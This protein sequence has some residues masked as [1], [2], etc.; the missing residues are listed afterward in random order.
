MRR[1]SVAAVILLCLFLSTQ[2]FGQTDASVSG[3]VTDASGGVIPGVTVTATNDNTGIVTT[4]VTNAAGVYNF[5][6]LLPGVYTVKAEQADF[7][8]KTITKLSL[9][10]SQQAR[11][12]FQLEVKG[13]ETKVEI[14]TSAEQLLLESGSSVGDVLD[15]EKVA[16][17]PL[18]NRNAL[19]LVKV[20]SGVVMADD[21][22]FNANSSSFAGVSA[23]G[24]NIQRDGVTVNDVR[25]PA[26]INAAT[27]VNPDLVGEFRMVLAP[28]DA[29]IG[30]GN[31][32]IQISTRSGTNE[33]HGSLVWNVQNTA[34]DPNTWE[35]NRNGTDPPWRNLHQYTASVGGPII[36][37]K[38]FFFALFDGQVNKIRTPYNTRV[39]TPCANQGIFRFYDYWNNGNARTTPNW[40][41][42]TPVYPLVNPDGSPRALPALKP[43]MLNPDGTQKPEW[44]PHNGVIRFASVFGALREGFVPDATCSN[45]NPAT[46]LVGSAWDANRSQE[47]PSGFVAE[48]KNRMPEVNNWDIGDGLNTAGHRWSRTLLGA[49]NLFGVGEDT[50][51]RQI[52]VRIDHNFSD[53][54]RIH[55]SWS[56]EKSWADDNFKNWPDGYGGKS[57]RRPQIL[58]VNLISSIRPTLLNEARFGMSRTGSNIYSPYTNPDTGAEVQAILPNVNGTPLIVG[59]GQGVFN[60]TPDD[61]SGNASGYFGGR[62]I[63]SYSGYDTSPRWTIGDTMSWTKGSHSFRFGGEYRR[64]S[65][66]A[67]NQWTGPFTA[68]YNSF[69]YAGGGESGGPVQGINSGNLGFGTGADAR[70]TGGSTTGNVSAM[71]DQLTYLSGALTQIRQWRYINNSSD[72]SWNDP[73]ADP[74]LVRDTVQKEFSMFF[75]DDWKVTPDLTL[76]LGVRYDYYGVPYL[77]NG[78]TTTLAG[79]AGNLFGLTGSSFDDWLNPINQD[80]VPTGGMSALEFVGEGTPN[81]DGILYPKDWNN[82]GPAVGFAYQ[83]PWFGKGKTTIRGGYQIN[84]IGNTG[85]AST[86]QSAAGEAPGTTYSNNYTGGG[87]YMDIQRVIN[88]GLV[89]APMPED[90]TPALKE[91]PLTNRLQN[92]TVFAPDYVSPYVQNLTF[93]LTRNITSNLMVDLRYVGTLS[94]KTYSNFNINF[95]N[96]IT[97]G[98]LEAFDSARAGGNP[99]LLDDLLMGQRLLP[100]FFPGSRVVDGVTYFGGDALRDAAW[101]N[102]AMAFGDP[103]A[104]T[105]LNQMLARGE[106]Q[107]LVNAMNSWGTPAGQLIRQNGFPENFMKTNPQFNNANFETNG[108][109]TNYH[110]F[111]AQVTLR[112]THGLDFQSTY[113]WAKSLGIGGGLPYDPRDKWLDY[114]LTGSDRRHNWVT[115]GNFALP[116]GPGKSIGKNTSGAWARVIEGWQASWITTVQSGAP[117][118]IGVRNG[119][120]G[121]GAPDLVGEFD[122]ESVGTYWPDGAAA[123]NYFGNRYYLGPDPQCAD[124][125]AGGQGLCNS[126][127]QS[128]YDIENDQIVFTNPAPGTQGNF[129]YNKINSPMRWNVDMALSKLIQ[130]DE[131]RSFRVR[132]DMANIFNHAQASGTLGSSGTRIVFPTAPNV[133]INT[134]VFG[135]MPYKVGG[136]TFQFMARFD[137]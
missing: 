60:F 80:T 94:R 31:A 6:R 121:I 93:A 99:Q 66:E 79:G 28:V 53:I 103:G 22:I 110:S 75:K 117:L 63:L 4:M 39:A 62:G 101:G 71:E 18:V 118:N 127:L 36:K 35:N 109:H 69:P 88:E 48:L 122:Y 14:S 56:W 72:T 11:L 34:L 43:N 21:T 130:I 50:Y 100:G 98:L 51:R 38:T 95:Q 26:G 37:N 107:G 108:G 113:S 102:Y 97:N 25:W 73:V 74:A 105:N 42:S 87:T 120:Y 58:T 89:P 76:N 33:L 67:H 125:W 3:T 45:Y 70:L 17:L 85:R 115:Y 2:A 44:Q 96:F 81:P 128:V 64:A 29:E 52:N 20:M 123:G 78:L 8:P 83:L 111:Q 131:T 24:V 61:F 47:D 16:E 112:P 104:F 19:D 15:S 10:S 137:F 1:L 135:N 12:N 55:G 82:I 5:P 27:R 119:M 46:D 49:D 41:S 133:S 136:R 54:H 129:G 90:I 7:Q 114:T 65:S 84:Y 77:E 116:F 132:V 57:E 126:G 30:R 106:Y 23:S 68:G 134:G 32:Q 59:H 124:V 40:T 91:F 92:M 9:L 86:I 13:V